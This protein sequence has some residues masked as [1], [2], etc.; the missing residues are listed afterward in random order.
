METSLTVRHLHRQSWALMLQ[1]QV[2]S[3]LSVREW[4][5]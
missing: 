2:F 4:Y 5:K 3:G 1:E